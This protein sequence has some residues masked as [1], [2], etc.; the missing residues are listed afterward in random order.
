M[1]EPRAGEAGNRSAHWQASA[2]VERKLES[3]EGQNLGIMNRFSGNVNKIHLSILSQ[4]I[5]L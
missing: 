1:L 4:V 5:F 3:R 2:V